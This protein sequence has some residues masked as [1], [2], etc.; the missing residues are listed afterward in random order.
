MPKGI[1]EI[2]EKLEEEIRMADGDP[3]SAHWGLEEGVLLTTNDAKTILYF[4][5]QLA[6]K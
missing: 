3:D 5:K 1:T 6:G 4:L 2:I